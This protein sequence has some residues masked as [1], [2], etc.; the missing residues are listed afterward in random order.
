MIWMILINIRVP[1]NRETTYLYGT[2]QDYESHIFYGDYKLIYDFLPEL[3]K[4]SIEIFNIIKEHESIFTNAYLKYL[5]GMIYEYDN[6]FSQMQ[7][8]RLETEENKEHK[9]LKLTQ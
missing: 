5:D 8:K 1:L 2:S 7:Q 9:T 4:F 3:Y 6:M